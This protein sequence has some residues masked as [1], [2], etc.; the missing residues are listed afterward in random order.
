MFSKDD[1]KTLLLA[2]A[3]IALGYGLLF[4]FHYISEWLGIYEQ[5]RY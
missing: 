5:L 3:I 2:A 4:G 1:L